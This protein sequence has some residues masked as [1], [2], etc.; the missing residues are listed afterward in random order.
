MCS[1]PGAF[2]TIYVL[3]FKLGVHDSMLGIM[4]T[5][6]QILTCFVYMLSPLSVYFMYMA[7]IVDIFNGVNS[8]VNRSLLAKSVSKDELGMYLSAILVD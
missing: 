2:G 4:G 5:V 1:F 6:S 8:T 7:P 3:G